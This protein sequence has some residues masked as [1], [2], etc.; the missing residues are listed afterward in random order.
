MTSFT[1]HAWFVRIILLILFLYTSGTC[2]TILHLFYEYE[3]RTAF[4][5]FIIVIRTFPR[6]IVQFCVS[7]KNLVIYSTL[8]LIWFVSVIAV[9][10]HAWKM[11]WDTDLEIFS[12]FKTLRNPN[13]CSELTNWYVNCNSYNLF[14]AS[15]CRIFTTGVF[16]VLDTK[17]SFQSVIYQFPLSSSVLVY[18]S[19]PC[20]EERLV[21]HKVKVALIIVICSTACHCSTVHNM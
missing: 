10:W 4:V 13:C 14:Y 15:I 5:P 9:A 11:W 8:W 6:S 3:H 20:M 12:L 16:R 2:I 1:V 7:D 18:W 21:I 19:L 17:K